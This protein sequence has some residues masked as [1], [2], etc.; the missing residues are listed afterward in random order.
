MQGTTSCEEMGTE[1]GPNEAVYSSE[2]DFS[3]S[4]VRYVPSPDICTQPSL[5]GVP[6][7]LSDEEAC[8]ECEVPVSSLGDSAVDSCCGSSTLAAEPIL[9]IDS[10]EIREYGTR[11]STVLAQNTWTM[12]RWLML[13]TAW[14]NAYNLT[15]GSVNPN[16]LICLKHMRHENG[17]YVGM[18]SS[19]SCK[20]C[21]CD[22]CSNKSELK[23]KTG[24]RGGPPPRQRQNY[25]DRGQVVL[26]DYS[27]NECMAQ[28]CCAKGCV[29]VLGLEGLRH[30]RTSL[31]LGG[32]SKNKSRPKHAQRRM[33]IC[34]EH[35]RDACSPL[36]GFKTFE[37]HWN[38]HGYS[39]CEAGFL[40]ISM[41]PESTVRAAMK[42]QTKQY[43]TGLWKGVL[44]SEKRREEATLRLKYSSDLCV[45]IENWI[46]DWANE[47]GDQMPHES[48]I[49]VPFYRWNAVYGEYVGAMKAGGNYAASMK[50]FREVWTYHIGSRIT[51]EKAYSKFAICDTCLS[52]QDELALCQTTVTRS[53]VLSKRRKHIEHQR[54]ERKM[55]YA[56]RDLAK[57]HPDLYMSIIMDKMDAF[58]W[59][60][61]FAHCYIL[62]LKL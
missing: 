44:P 62:Y 8:V 37:W 23:N 35:V 55:Y 2:S 58:K 22:S 11:D 33:D 20:G 50:Y 53:E 49:R 36:D 54:A 26:S 60:P 14:G 24:V 7:C 47:V 13:M 6:P 12:W 46:N 59:Y 43:T 17:K 18:C 48:T 57:A 1:I 30:Y 10:P 19:P 15:P 21:A 16:A 42:A 29:R 25:I 61:V 4:D 38:V 52:L 27:L 3:D 32:N 51:L 56:K 28:S 40:W 31:W 39:V 34:R 5:V 9:D 41:L 45:N